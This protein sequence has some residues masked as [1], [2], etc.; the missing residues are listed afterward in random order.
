MLWRGFGF[1]GANF[2]GFNKLINSTCIYMQFELNM[3]KQYRKMICCKHFV[4]VEHFGK[5]RKNV[6]EE[7]N[8]T[9]SVNVHCTV[10]GIIEKIKS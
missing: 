8:I 9:V 6:F 2:P 10:Y 1:A 5:L 3:Q 7:F 4:C